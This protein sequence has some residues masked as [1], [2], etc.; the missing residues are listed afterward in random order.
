MT[1]PLFAKRKVPI[2][3]KTKGRTTIDEKD[4]IAQLE[5]KLKS[6][7][8]I[9]AKKIKNDTLFFDLKV[10]DFKMKAKYKRIN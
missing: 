2:A 8:R 7:L 6:T 4:P 5:T 9:A 3:T 1:R 10:R